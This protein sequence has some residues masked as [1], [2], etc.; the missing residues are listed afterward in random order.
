MLLLIAAPGLARAQG[1][2]IGLSQLQASHETQPANVSGNEL[3]Y[4]YKT[5]T[6]VV[7]GN[8]LLTQGATVLSAD[9]LEYTRGRRE[10]RA[11]GHVDLT[12][13][14]VRMRASQA[15]LD[16]D[17]ES[18]RLIDGNLSLLNGSYHLTG[19]EITKLPG[20]RYSVRDGFFTTCGCESGR[21]S[22]SIGAD[23]MD[24]HLGATG[25]ASWPRFNILEYPVLKLPY[26]IFPAD[27]ERSS[28]LLS[29]RLGESR[30]R[31]FQYFQ[32]FYLT[33]DKSSDATLALDVETAARVGF[34]GEYRV[35][36]GEDDYLRLTGAYMDESIRS[37]RTND[38]VDEQIADPHVPVDR[39]EVIGL[40]RQHLT[41]DLILFGDTVT[42]SDSL[43]L[44]EMNVYTLSR[45][46]GSN[47]GM[48][49]DAP[50][51]FGL[52][53]S[54]EDG[55]VRLAGTWHEDLIQD[56]RFALQTLPELLFSGRRD[57]AGGLAYGDYDAQAVNFWRADG[58][59]GM[60]LDL[61]PRVTMPWRLGDYVTGFGMLGA[62]ETVY[63]ASGHDIKVIPV[64]TDGLNNNN[65]LALDGLGAG[66]LQSR[67]L[68]Y[69][70]AGA[71]T[72]IEKVYDLNW[73]SIEKVKHTIEPLATYSYVPTVAQGNL[74]LFDD[75]DRVNQRSLLSY[76]AVSRLFV[77]MTPK[78]VDTQEAAGSAGDDSDD[79]GA[80][81]EE[82]G[83]GGGYSREAARLTLLQSYDLLRRITKGGSQMSDLNLGASLFPTSVASFGSQ[84]GYS[85]QDR[86]I[87]NAGVNLL[88]RPPWVNTG[89]SL[90]M[91]RAVAGPFLQVE[92]NFVGYNGASQT[93]AARV[94]YE[95]FD[96]LG[97]YYGPVYDI[98]GGKLL[99]AEYGLRVK[100]QC[101][102]WAV[103]LGIADTTN[104]N[105][106]QFQFQLT[107]G[108]LGSV[109]QSPFGRNPF[110]NYYGGTTGVVPSMY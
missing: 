92:Y 106:V 103:D 29:P 42:V 57:L 9:E 64:G 7:R 58:I 73:E 43:Y 56:Q 48:L 54:F 40:T 104:P 67:Q 110:R 90:Y 11:Y 34:V 100:S 26:M 72:E 70:S 46:Y 53:Q 98:A 31:G 10:A 22:W 32:P 79:S 75:V 6:I 27:A 102:C 63:D 69:G 93:F 107:L 52:L 20:Q 91:G 2:P 36:N 68:L 83:A 88:V 45:G 8:A 77:K 62:R 89:P 39:Y 19:K 44:R 16:L 38:V 65:G 76:G 87:T 55:F 12:D 17:D 59:R 33:I 109:G 30:L 49:R 61:N 23:Q 21:P 60:R 13:P 86:R 50:S 1:R 97:V 80:A 15:E 3:V 4:D 81:P 47:F 101:N 28:G 14:E 18:G 5:D 105:E 25:S 95:L 78:A 24:V 96:R 51:H 74:P 99:S 71:S 37:N 35:S 108:G 66:G 82:T 41:P 85:V 94:Y 84:I